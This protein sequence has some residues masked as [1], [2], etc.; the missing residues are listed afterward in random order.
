MIIYGKDTTVSLTILDV[1]KSN[2]NLFKTPRTT[3][4]NVEIT[5]SGIEGDKIKGDFSKLKLFAGSQIYIKG[6]LNEGVYTV[7]SVEKQVMY[8]IVTIEPLERDLYEFLRALD[9]PTMYF[10]NDDLTADIGEYEVTVIKVPNSFRGLYYKILN[11]CQEH[12]DNILS[13]TNGVINE[14]YSTESY[15]ERFKAELSA[16]R[17]LGTL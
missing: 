9:V 10:Y 2:N 4:T 1:M 12:A 8:D 5:T 17:K 16:F 11:Y 3:T 7:K 15:Q 6:D 13:S 14:S